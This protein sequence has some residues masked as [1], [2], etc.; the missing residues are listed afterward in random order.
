MVS[1]DVRVVDGEVSVLVCVEVMGTLVVVV[2]V[3]VEVS[4][5]E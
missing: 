4:V 2:V 5:V 1:V 3:S